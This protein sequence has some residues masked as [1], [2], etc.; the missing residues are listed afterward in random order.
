MNAILKQLRQFTE[1]LLPDP[2]AWN[3]L[4]C[5]VGI[6][7]VS[8]LPLGSS[9][10]QRIRLVTLAVAR[11]VGRDPQDVL[12]ELGAFL[13]ARV[14]EGRNEGSTI[15]A[16]ERFSA[17]LRE[18]GS[19]SSV[20]LLRQSPDRGVVMHAPET[21]MCGLWLGLARGFGWHR[22]EPLA[23]VQRTC[24]GRGA[25]SCAIDVER[26]TRG[27]GIRRIGVGPVEV[28]DD[29]TLMLPKTR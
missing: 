17:Q 13:S 26:C 18:D 22:G 25:A 14:F 4:L 1:T 21:D 5:D 6:S 16:L 28:D 8:L 24:V 10:E 9:I 19:A 23:I 15:D 11:R 7:R 20:A 2:Y 3:T 27:S 12:E 29:G